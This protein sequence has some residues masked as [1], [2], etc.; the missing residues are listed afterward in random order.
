M[1]RL[2]NPAALQFRCISLMLVIIQTVIISLN[3][4]NY[5]ILIIGEKLWE[6]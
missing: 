4:Y 2:K 6:L 3:K 1:Q 5:C